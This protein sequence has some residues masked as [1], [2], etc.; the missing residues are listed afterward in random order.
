MLEEIDQTLGEEPSTHVIIPVGVGSLAQAVVSHYKSSGIPPTAVISVEPDTAAP[1]H[2]SLVSGKVTNIALQGTIMNGLNCGTLSKIAWPVL[3]NGID[4]SV[5]VSDFEAHEAVEYLN[6]RGIAA[7]PCGGASLAALRYIS[8]VKPKELGLSANSVVTLICSEGYR[9]YQLPSDVSMSDA[10]SLTQALVRIDS[11]NPALSR[12]AGETVIAN[13]IAAWLEHRD[14]EVHKLQKTPGR[15]TIVGVARGTGGGRS[16]MFNGHVDTVTLAGYKGDPLSGEIRD[17]KLYG[18]GSNDMKSGLAA[19]LVAAVEAKNA[20]VRGDVI[21]AAVA[22]EES[23]SL[24]TEELLEAGWT[25]DGAI[26][27]EPTSQDVSLAHKGF[28]WLEVDVLG[29]A[30]HGSNPSTGID[31]IVKA[32]YFLVE[33]EKYGSRLLSGDTVH[34]ALGTGTVHASLIKGGEEPSSYPAECTITVERRTIP[35]ET[36]SLVVSQFTDILENLK[37]SIPDFDYRIRVTFQRQPLEVQPDNPFIISALNS[38]ETVIGH[39]PVMKG[40]SYWTDC[41]LLSEKGI[42][43]FLFGP[44]GGG[45]H[46]ETEWAETAS[47]EEVTRSLTQVVLDFCN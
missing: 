2:K 32:G 37:R 5:T 30:G 44:G 12:G 45:L 9:P 23:G 14:F 34:P 18:R 8:R 41:A 6:S 3:Q 7:G 22:D 27:T 42:P 46:A 24:G 4:A 15:P 19:A 17:G 31:A 13:F 25:A 33:L 36:Q 39:Q 47:I 21:V 38:I 26:I 35:S 10:V 1:L 29:K 11:S 16:I 20:K 28:I 43:C 40:G